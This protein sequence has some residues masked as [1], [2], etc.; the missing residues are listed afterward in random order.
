M[1]SSRGSGAQN[2]DYDSNVQATGIRDF[3]FVKSG[4]KSVKMNLSEIIYGEGLE[5][6]VVIH[7]KDKKYTN[8]ERMKNLENQLSDQ[9]LLRIHKS[10]IVSISA[11]DAVFGNTVEVDG[12]QLHIGRS[13]KEE[14]EKVL[15][16][17]S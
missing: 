2:N 1:G 7:T 6:Y 17:S 16:M 4:Y 12:L 15:G 14:I 5:E 8:P 3:V 11:I 9:G 13:Y 10:Y